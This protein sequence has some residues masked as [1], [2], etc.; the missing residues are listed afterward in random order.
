MVVPKL[1]NLIQHR[2]FLYKKLFLKNNSTSN[3]ILE[4]S[5]IKQIGLENS[6][7]LYVILVLYFFTESR[8]DYRTAESVCAWNFFIYLSDQIN[9]SGWPQLRFFISH[10]SSS[11]RRQNKCKME[12]DKK[13][14]ELQGSRPPKYSYNYFKFF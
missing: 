5:K 1:E 4:N 11:K 2:L 8:K 7:S 13:I 9:C 12:L 3:L 6:T 10:S 14:I